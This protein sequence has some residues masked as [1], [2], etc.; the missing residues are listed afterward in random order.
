MITEVKAVFE[1]GHMDGR[2]LIIQPD[3]DT[4]EFKKLDKPF[5]EG[6]I[7][8]TT[9]RYIKVDQNEDGTVY[10]FRTAEGILDANN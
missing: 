7:Q 6:D 10:T 4:L 2:T 9:V 8:L 3:Q 5:L 1:G